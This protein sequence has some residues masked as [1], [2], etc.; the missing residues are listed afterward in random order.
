MEIIFEIKEN[1]EQIK[2][3]MKSQNPIWDW[4]EVSANK[5]RLCDAGTE[6]PSS[7]ATVTYDDDYIHIITDLSNFEYEIFPLGFHTFVKYEGAYMGLL[8]QNLLPTLTPVNLLEAKVASSLTRDLRYDYTL[9]EYIVI[10]E[11]FVSY[12]KQAGLGLY[13]NQYTHP[14][15]VTDLV[16]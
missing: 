10:R 8:E 1:L 14:R 13:T 6:F 16:E 12:K 11:S 3:N 4:K 9:K 2:R 7:A 5:G 15:C